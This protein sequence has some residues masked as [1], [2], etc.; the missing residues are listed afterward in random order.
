MLNPRVPKRI[1]LIQGHPDRRAIRFGRLLANAYSEGAAQAGHA[2][3]VIDVATLTFPLVSTKD[4]VDSGAVPD[5]IRGAQEAI[6]WAEH[7]VIFYPLWLGSTP[8]LLKGFLEQVFRP[9][10]AYEVQDAGRSWK[11]R[12]TG[13]TARIV[14]T[15]AM[16]AF[17]YRWYF[18]AH[19][20]KSLERN[21][22][23]F[24]G[25]GPVR[26]S[27][28]GLIESRDNAQRV[29]WLAKMRVLGHNAA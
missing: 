12:L 22:L 20:L 16:P 10:F 28:I 6:A 26:D 9:G 21:I 7:L 17:I 18:F 1:T 25:I 4:E 15:M 5:A 2:I 8:A 13:K 3:R 29:K 23:G 24:C 11:K 27:L 14:V 19:G